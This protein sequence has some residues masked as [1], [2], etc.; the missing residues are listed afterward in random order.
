MKIIVCVDR[1][2]GGGAQRVAAMWVT[3]WCARGHEVS[4]VVSNSRTPITYTIPEGVKIHSIDVPISNGYIR[5]FAKLL[6]SKR[7]LEKIFNKETPDLVVS[8]APT[9]GP[10]IYKA[11]GNM[12]FVVIGTDHNSFERPA[13]APM[14]NKTHWLK[15]EFSKKFDHYTVLTEADK[16]V[17]GDKLNNVSVLPNPLA[18]T[19]VVDVPSKKRIV[20]A[21]G[22]L[23]AGHSKGFDILIKAFGMSN[24]SGWTLQIAGG[25]SK[26]SLDIYTKLAEECGVRESVEFLGFLDN[27]IQA[28]RDAGIFCLSSRY[29]GFGLVVT[30]AMSQ[31]CACVVCDYKGRQRE[32]IRN[33]SEG[34]I[35]E[36][37]N[38]QSL[39]V[40]LERMM[41]DD[42]YRKAVQHNSPMRAAD[43]SID[44]IM[45]KWDV[46]FKKLGLMS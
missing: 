40:C 15:F 23:D 2:T 41:Q 30:E 19:P 16:K 8:I 45:D 21:M 18:F 5:H 4:I 6:T 29:E 25:G 28:Y 44:K 12:S 1:L 24:H 36:P 46:I 9:W 22:R 27:P 31:G 33:E 13:S 14:P 17:I 39:A 37:D 20:L 3:G 32:I 10:L 26:E 7:K 42:K 34:L 35:C 38:P 11:K 43:Y